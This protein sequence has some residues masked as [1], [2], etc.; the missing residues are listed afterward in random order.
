MCTF[1][2]LHSR[3]LYLARTAIQASLYRFSNIL[4]T[5]P[6][7]LL[8]KESVASRLYFF[9]DFIRI[10]ISVNISVS[11]CTDSAHKPFSVEGF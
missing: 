3:I 9:P 2:L 8:G 4:D 6:S 11:N 10:Y 7:A 1:C 5:L